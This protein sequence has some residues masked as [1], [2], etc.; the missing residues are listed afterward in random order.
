MR[1]TLLFLLLFQFAN[2]QR[3]DSEVYTYSPGVTFTV[4]RITH[5]KTTEYGN[6]MDGRRYIAPSGMHFKGAILEFKNDSGENVIIDF[7]QV[8]LIDSKGEKHKV[9]SVV[10]SMKVT[11]TLEKLRQKLKA[12][13]EKM[14]IVDF[15]PA[16]SKEDMVTKMIVNGQEVIF[17]YR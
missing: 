17:S 9:E 13:K 10:Q 16:F 12:G 5:A 8:F 3:T 15:W 7:E 11:N 2:A 6:G 1:L 4:V 14:F